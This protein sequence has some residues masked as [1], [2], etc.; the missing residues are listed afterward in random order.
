MFV[1]CWLFCEKSDLVVVGS[2]IIFVNK[3]VIFKLVM[4]MFVYV[5][6]WLFCVKIISINVFEMMF[7]IVV[8]ISIR[9]KNIF[10]VGDS[11]GEFLFI[12]VLFFV[13]FMIFFK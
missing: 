7:I 5:W 4:K 13:V 10:E 12:F 1:I 9:V 6:R 8:K 3:F 2:K 11:V